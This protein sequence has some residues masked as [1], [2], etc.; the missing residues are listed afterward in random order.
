MS[1]K[2]S[3]LA[4]VV[5]SSTLKK[6]ASRKYTRDLA[7]YLLDNHLTGEVDSL[8]RDVQALWAKSGHLEVLTSSA[9]PLTD[10]IKSEIRRQV[11]KA[12]PK[13]STIVVTEV[14]DEQ[15]IGGVRINLPGRQLDL[16]IEAKLNRFKQL[17]SEGKE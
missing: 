16:S 14:Y 13:A 9:H 15:V 5:A 2:R 10:S 8:M 7:A 4:D 11:K 6:G 17:V 12:A 1:T 3:E